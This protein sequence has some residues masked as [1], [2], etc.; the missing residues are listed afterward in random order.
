MAAVYHLSDAGPRAQRGRDED[1]DETRDMEDESAIELAAQ[2]LAAARSVAMLTGAGASAE[3]GVPTFRDA[4]TGLWAQFDPMQLATPRAFA[5]H[6]KLVWDWYAWRRELVAKVKPNPAHD[7]LADIERRIA[8]CLLITQNV[9]GLH[10]RAGSRRVV[11]L[12]GNIARVRCSREG[13]VIDHWESS[14]DAVP[15]CPDCGALLRPDVVWFEEALD[16][17]ALAAAESMARRCDVMLV[18]GTSAEVYPAAALPSIARSGGAIVIE[19]N[20]NSTALSP[21][22]DFRLRGP[23]GAILPALIRKAW[24]QEQA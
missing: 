10:R 14:G 20:P 4:Q 2:T 16:P 24:P 8:D 6:P 13:T 23:A 11:E 22:A 19:I 1:A 12:H 9:D 21:M 17:D 18:V 7:A 3:S 5:A 15:R